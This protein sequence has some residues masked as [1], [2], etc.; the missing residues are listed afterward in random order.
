MRSCA[1]SV[2]QCARHPSIAVL[3]FHIFVFLV[4]DLHGTTIKHKIE[5][6]CCEIYGADGCDYSDAAKQKIED[7]SRLGTSICCRKLQADGKE[8]FFEG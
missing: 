6:I 8:N 1:H 7:Y 2:L 3:T 4:D 5:T